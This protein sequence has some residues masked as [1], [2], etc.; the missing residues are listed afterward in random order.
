MRNLALELALSESLVEIKVPFN[1][2]IFRLNASLLENDAINFYF[3]HL[4]TV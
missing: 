1:F 4:E 3:M 2:N